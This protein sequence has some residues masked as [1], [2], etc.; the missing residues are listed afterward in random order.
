[1]SLFIVFVRLRHRWTNKSPCPVGPQTNTGGRI[2][3]RGFIQGLQLTVI[4]GISQFPQP[5]GS[6]GSHT[7]VGIEQ[8]P[9]PKSRENPTISQ[10]TQRGQGTLSHGRV[11]IGQGCPQNRIGASGFKLCERFNR[12]TTA[13]ALSD[14]Q[15]LREYGNDRL[16]G[17]DLSQRLRGCLFDGIVR[18]AQCA[19][20]A[21]GC[22]V[23]HVFPYLSQ[24]PGAIFTNLGIGIG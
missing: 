17:A 20:K 23:V 19:C 24:G 6:L 3:T 18:V 9:F 10:L 4:S 1:M 13:A 5:V 7:R 15:R 16:T 22:P 21:D 11:R 2:V 12:G 8:E 14:G